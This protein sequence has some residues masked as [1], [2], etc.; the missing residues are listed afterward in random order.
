MKILDKDADG[1]VL[2]PKSMVLIGPPGCGKTTAALN[3][4]LLPGISDAGPDAILGC[5]FTKAAAGEMRQKLAKA[6]GIGYRDTRN[7]VRTIHSESLR[8]LRANGHPGVVYDEKAKKEKKTTSKI[9]DD[10]PEDYGR[11]A[12]GTPCKAL[13]DE[14]RRI[15]RIVR[16]KYPDDLGQPIDRLISREAGRA[17][18]SIQDMAAEVRAYEGEKRQLGHIDFEDMLILALDVPSPDRALLVIDEAQDLSPLQLRVTGHWAERTDRLVWIG[19]PDQGIYTFSGADGDFLKQ[20]IRAGSEVRRLAQGYRCPAPVRNLARNLIV[21]GDDREDAD[22]LAAE[23]G[24]R[25][26]F[27]DRP[28]DGAR[29]GAASD[30]TVF[31]LSRTG[32]GLAGY[33]RMLAESGVP[34][35]QERGGSSPLRETSLANAIIA[36]H[37]LLQK[38]DVPVESAIH[39]LNLLKYR[40][41]W[42]AA[43]GDM[44]KAKEELKRMAKNGRKTIDYYDLSEMGLRVNKLVGGT[45]DVSIALDRMKLADPDGFL[46]RIYQRSGVSGLIERPKITLTTIHS[47]KGREA[48]TVILDRNCPFPS[49]KEIGSGREGW[50]GE[51]RVLYVGIT[52]TKRDLCMIRAES[53]EQDMGELLGMDESSACE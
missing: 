21:Q 32:K 19:D 27:L 36:L 6:S 28:E 42:Y 2:G 41:G 39:L 13:R 8:L 40:D 52:R 3:S 9:E 38:R 34:F 12:M 17:K 7:T 1:Y 35:L 46:L 31:F 50:N 15:W 53:E 16:H 11:D 48:D 10:D 37:Y 47:S 14:S 20:K 18:F 5:S 30:G 49:R 33:A 25:V 24:G 22:Y 43:R 26:V 29:L 4:W 23:H 45:D 44:G 51:L